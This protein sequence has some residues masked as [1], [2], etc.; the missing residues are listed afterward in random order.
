MHDD[1]SDLWCCGETTQ[2][3]SG[4]DSLALLGVLEMGALLTLWKT[5]VSP[6][7]HDNSAKPTFLLKTNYK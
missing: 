3:S 4:S 6:D 1:F 2:H 7:S 5:D